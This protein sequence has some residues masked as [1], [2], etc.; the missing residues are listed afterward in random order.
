MIYDFFVSYKWSKHSRE[1]QQLVTETAAAQGLPP[2][3]AA[4]H[5]DSA[6]RGVDWRAAHWA[7]I[8][9]RDRLLLQATR[10]ELSFTRK[11]AGSIQ[12]QWRERVGAAKVSST[13]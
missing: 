12:A 8:P 10:G 7:Q 5:Q 2:E 9:Q 6:H 11:Q 4:F 3:T 13:G 1:A